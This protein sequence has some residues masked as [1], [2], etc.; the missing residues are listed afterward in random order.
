MQPPPRGRGPDA[1]S[2]QGSLGPAGDDDPIVARIRAWAR[3]PTADDTLALCDELRRTPTVR[4]QHV[5][6]LA[7]AVVQRH[8]KDALVLLALGRLQLAIGKLSDAQ[9]TL[10]SAGRSDPNARG[11]Y[12]YL[13]EVLLR[14][15]D[16]TRA[17]RMLEKAVEFES[18]SG[19]H[20][21]PSE[22]PSADW[23]IRARA[24]RKTQ[25]AQGEGA[26]AA[27]MA[28]I[29]AQKR[30]SSASSPT[31]PRSSL[32]APA[33][34]HAESDDEPTQVGQIPDDLRRRA[35]PGF[36]TQMGADA[37]AALA[38]T[39]PASPAL[40]PQ[41]TQ[42]AIKPPPSH[43][44]S[45]PE[46]P[47]RPSQNA[48]RPQPTRPP[49]PALPALKTQP[50][51]PPL[52]ALKPTATTPPA[53]KPRTTPP[54]VPAPM[55]PPSRPAPQI[56]ELPRF[57]D[58][59]IKTRLGSDDSGGDLVNTGDF[60][61]T[62]HPTIQRRRDDESVPRLPLAPPRDYAPE[63]APEPPP[64]SRMERTSTGQ[65]RALKAQSVTLG[66]P[67]SDERIKTR[68]LRPTPF[69]GGSDALSP[70]VGEGQGQWDTDKVLGALE[71]AGVYEKGAAAASPAQWM[72]RRE[73]VRPRRRGGWL[74]AV[75]AVVVIG[76]IGGAIYGGRAYKEKQRA[77]ADQATLRAEADVRRGNLDALANA[78]KDLGHAF[79][80]DSRTLRGA[81]VWLQDRVLRSYVWP[82]DERHE[83]GLA[84][85]IERGKT[86]GLPE[87]ELA[88]ARIALALSSDDTPSAAAL[89]KTLDP[90]TA[91]DKADAWREL[92]VG[93]V[94][95]RA[96]DARA[97]DR[98]SH[99]VQLDP[100]L[101]V[102]RLA[103]AKLAALAGDL[104]RVASL[105]KD[106]AGELTAT[107]Q[108]LTALATF[109]REGKHESGGAL[110][111]RRPAGFGWIASALLVA[112]PKTDPEVRRKEAARA[113]ALARD[114]GD[115]T[116]IGRFAAA[117]G[118]EA[119]AS[120]A[121]LRALEASPIFPP[122]RALG[123]RLALSVGRPDDAARALEGVTSEGDA[124]LAAL[125]AWLSYERGDLTEVQR[126]LDNPTVA[127]GALDR[128][129]L[130]PIVRPLRFAI[131][132]RTST[133]LSA[134]DRTEL[135]ALAGLGELGPLVAFDIAVGTLEL[136]VAES[137]SKKW[138]EDAGQ[139]PARA[140]RL[141][142]LARLQGRAEDADK[143]SKIAVEQAT[144]TPA[145]LIE[146]VLVLGGVGKG[147]DALAL[148]ARYPLLAADEQPWLRAWSTAQAGKMAD[149]K[150][151]V[152]A[153]KE[154]EKKAPW[155][156]RR[157]ALLALSATSDKRAKAYAK[158]LAK[159]R[160]NDP[161]VR[162]IGRA[163][164]VL[165]E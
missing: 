127:G 149:A 8:A 46:R 86:V 125:H 164:G 3:R 156:V 131:A 55:F 56:T 6:A 105:T 96:G 138:V 85:A 143:M 89:A 1:P 161:D 121:A 130:A 135:E 114:P 5:D 57:E 15:G 68:P 144:V 139:R 158:E 81:R 12:R 106:F 50:T 11:P 39:S 19:D 83:G 98:Y 34:V 27:E 137:I 76:G 71:R 128:A 101:V 118:D 134:K 60:V 91:K 153:L 140:L 64:E 63:P 160:A 141:A 61:A 48:L 165:K 104:D 69:P 155:A 7:R 157:D 42:S 24:L 33:V 94:L 14:R 36:Q 16:A 35:T 123:A 148:L 117:A 78:E 115:L 129:D 18:K 51:P 110:E 80:L 75:L 31:P 82:T 62:E 47:S 159:E 30:P 23:L 58:E 90:G 20:G 53:L 37:N 22:E 109:I 45:S 92:T 120:R 103:L 72:H 9:Q 88:F 59:S 124:E 145:A 132:K 163:L 136:T 146:R 162:A 28:S 21:D 79:E 25:E 151:Q 93:W 102:A 119:T 150:K 73:I 66:E 112:D 67:A 126:A 99:A 142:R 17:E 95:E 29:L 44:S 32:R 133:N 100:E 41:A 10:V 122:A 87:G 147:A 97:A 4:G 108:D 13:G 54:P 70:R 40:R 154:P 107:K 38:A 152:E 2:Q 116:R 49:L 113:T 111:P 26:V 65:L 43:P 52:P 74:Y 77:E 84:S